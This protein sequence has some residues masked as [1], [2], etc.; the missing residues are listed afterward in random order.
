MSDVKWIRPGLQLEWGGRRMV[1]RQVGAHILLT[2]LDG[3]GQLSVPAAEVAVVLRGTVAP[4]DLPR[5][6]EVEEYLPVRVQE[7]LAADHEVL[8]IM[9]T[10]RRS[11]QPD[12]DPPAPA[13]DPA[14]VPQ[15]VRCRRMATQL[16][17]SCR[18]SGSMRGHQ[19]LV[20]SEMRRIQRIMKRWHDGQTLLDARYTKPGIWRTDD[21]VFEALL[22]FVHVHAP[23]STKSKNALVRGFRIHCV[24]E[25]PEL[26]LPSDSTLWLRVSEIRGA[27]KELGGTARNRISQLNVPTSS[28]MTRLA[29]RPGELVL[30][31][32]TKSNVWV[33]DPRTDRAYRLDVT[34]AIDL[35][36][37]CI[38]GLAITHTTTKFAIG[39]CLADVLRPKTAVLASEWTAADGQLR[40]QPFVG[41]PD[42]FVSFHSAAF[43]PEGVV[44]DNGKPYISPYVTAQMARLQ[45]HYEP[46]RSYNPTDKAQ[47]ERV[48]RTIKDMFESEMPGFT[49]GSVH[50]RGASPETEELLTP[51]QYERR[52]RQCIDLYNHKD[53]AGLVLPED[54]FA[55]LSP[56]VMYGILAAKV[57]AIADIEYQYDWVRFLPS[58]LA[59]VEPS[60]VRVRRLNYRSPALAQLQGD[61]VVVKNGK[62]RVYYDPFDLRTTWCFDADGVLHPL[63]WAYLRDVTPRFGEF[64]TNW[65]VR[66]HGGKRVSTHEVERILVG[67]F[68]GQYDAEFEPAR[69]GLLADTLMQARAA[70]LTDG[71]LQP[72]TTDTQQPEPSAVAPST[73]RGSRRGR[74]RRKPRQAPAVPPALPEGAAPSDAVPVVPV[75]VPV[76]RPRYALR[77]YNQDRS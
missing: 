35:A 33:R 31:D 5:L 49:G 9:L 30:F 44:V 58:V 3:S 7:R 21:A 25:H 15:G 71:L 2:Q 19:V 24:R 48:F 70:A 42:A 4:V 46:Q 32:T 12:T 47:V 56:Y 22:A 45:I 17:D 76:V 13:L 74:P 57:G 34:L 8:H 75:V 54:P 40:E 61:P 53:H 28:G 39:L 64:H 11:D 50:E 65:A 27:F 43:H 18:R 16:A 20:A 67:I 41:R 59:T 66:T 69:H 72:A 52:L 6:H 73:L 37:R 10:G 38:V 23:K 77:P 26:V 63:R 14:R 51:G 62:L 55:R 36:T 1:I 29:T 60:R 68:A